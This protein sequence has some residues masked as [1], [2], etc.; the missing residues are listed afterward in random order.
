MNVFDLFAKISLDSKDYDKGVNNAK[1][2]FKGLGNAIGNGVKKVGAG[3]VKVGAAVATGLTAAGAGIAA[4]AKQS[5]AAYADYEQ[6]VG[7]VETL[8]SNLE[9]TVSAAP[10]VLENANRAY[11]TAGLSANE[12]METVTAFSAALIAG[13]NND[14]NEAARISDMAISDMADNS[15]KMGTAMESVQ[16][17]Y[18][19]FAKQN[20]TMLDNL[21]LGYGGTK[22][23]MER[24]L[25][26]AEKLSGVKYDISNLADVYEAIHVIQTEMGITGTTAREAEHTITG[27]I[28]ATKSAW[29]NLIAGFASDDADIGQLIDN[30]VQSGLT[31]LNN[32]LPAAE[33]AI[34]GIALG[35]EKLAPIIG[36]KLPAII[37]DVLPSV[38]GAAS[39]LIQSVVKALPGL[40]E[41][42]SAEAPVVIMTLVTALLG[43]LPLVLDAARQVILN[44][45]TALMQNADEIL[46]SAYVL[47]DSLL[48]GL[49]ETLPRVV[50]MAEIIIVKLANGLGEYIPK[51]LPVAL[52]LILTLCDALLS[53]I[54]LIL[55]AALDL[56]I[57]LAE[58]IL[59][60]LPELA[61]RA[62]QIVSTIIT[63]L[64]EKIPDLISAA[65]T[66]LLAILEALPVIQGELAREMPDLVGRVCDSLISMMPQLQNA[67]GQL[68]STLLKVLPG[69]IWQLITQAVTGW[70]DIIAKILSFGPQL[71][72]TVKTMWSNL[73]KIMLEQAHTLLSMVPQWGKD[74]IN[75]FVGGIRAKISAVKDT[76][77]NV[78]STIKRILGFSEP[79]EGPLSNFH[80]YAPDMIDL[81]NKGVEQNERKLKGTISDAFNFQPT[82][83]ASAEGNYI[84]NYNSSSSGLSDA[85]AAAL[86]SAKIAVVIDGRKT[87]GYLSPEINSQLGDLNSLDGRGLCLA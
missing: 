71:W 26:D 56:V 14:Y 45:A 41:V 65:T 28:A 23:E 39:Q 35:I 85:I 47:I 31:A 67:A 43:Q 72:E 83:E 32:I 40:L 68:F 58:G 80:T 52:D 30:L 69:I 46:E 87:V 86:R 33:K 59:A 81:F 21:K 17:A 76:I 60:A 77:S 57:N 16:A 53:H 5:V 2:S 1:S 48:R 74:L 25:A 44:L 15:N 50:E 3:M 63:V 49:T 37:S 61:S 27:S 29:T 66:L 75:N 38:L 34:S 12:Y 19:G 82:I 11:K 18:Q 6:L 54:D 4:L 73:R 42:L 24:L 79:E 64:L 10:Q 7:G 70:K 78:A 22:T 20:Y 84:S 62:P 13:L 9:G 8:F 36:E 55:D 51:L